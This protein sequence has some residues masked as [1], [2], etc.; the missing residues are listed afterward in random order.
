MFLTIEDSLYNI[1]KKQISAVVFFAVIFELL[2]F[3][4]YFSETQP[5]S[6]FLFNA[7]YFFNTIAIFSACLLGFLYFSVNKNK[8]VLLVSLAILNW[9]F[10]IFFWTSYA[11]MLGNPITYPSIAQMAFHGF[12]LIMLPVLLTL[13]VC[14]CFYG[15]YHTQDHLKF[16]FL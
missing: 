16:H 2:Y 1:S 14:S 11:F 6:S 5:L 13:P 8:I 12:H 15:Y 3:A 7:L 10:G 4:G 9:F